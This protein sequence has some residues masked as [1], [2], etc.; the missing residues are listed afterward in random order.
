M[1][2]AHDHDV[3]C[4]ETQMF[5][6]QESGQTINKM[7]SEKSGISHFAVATA[8]TIQLIGTFNLKGQ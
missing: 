8:A 4:M 2:T 5:E 7:Q 6:K 3:Y 1:T